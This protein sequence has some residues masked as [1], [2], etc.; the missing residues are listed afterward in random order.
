M[1]CRRVL[2]V[3]LDDQCD[4]TKVSRQLVTVPGVSAVEA[5]DPEESITGKVAYLRARA[6]LLEKLNEVLR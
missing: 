3:A 1:A 5:V 4:W 6:D 2:L